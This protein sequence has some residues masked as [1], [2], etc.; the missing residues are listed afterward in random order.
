[1]LELDWMKQLFRETDY[2]QLSQ[3]V[4]VVVRCQKMC[5][6]I[7][8]RFDYLISLLP[9]QVCFLGLSTEEGKHVHAHFV[10]NIIVCVCIYFVHATYST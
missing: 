2:V 6:L 10:L 4:S 7:H 8:Y 3:R 9:F 1:M 5:L